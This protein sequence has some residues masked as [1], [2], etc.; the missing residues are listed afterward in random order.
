[1]S[2]CCP[3]PKT[4]PSRGCVTH[5]MTLPDTTYPPPPKRPPHPVFVILIWQEAEKDTV[6]VERDAPDTIPLQ[7]RAPDV[8]PRSSA[9]RHLIQT[10]LR[11]HSSVLRLLWMHRCLLSI[12][13]HFECYSM[14]QYL[15]S[16]IWLSARQSCLGDLF[17]FEFC[18]QLFLSRNPPWPPFKVEQTSSF[19]NLT[20]HFCWLGTRAQ[21]LIKSDP[22]G[23]SGFHAAHVSSTTRCLKPLGDAKERVVCH[24]SS[25]YLNTGDIT[26]LSIFF[27]F[28][29]IRKQR[30]R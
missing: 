21:L 5:L 10:L 22:S 16:K 8:G 26:S 24:L 1:M 15:F 3:P 7:A 6:A 2:I 14:A 11:P 20:A 9:S 18:T 12:T 19:S 23:F 25:S 28:F 13:T 4:T 30:G 27:F 17:Q 29:Y